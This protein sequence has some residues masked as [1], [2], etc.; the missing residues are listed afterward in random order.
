[1][2][3]GGKK[4][5]LKAAGTDATKQFD[6]FHNASVLQ[7]VAAPFLI[8]EVGLKEEQEE[9]ERPPLTVGYT[10]GDMIPFG[11]PMWQVISAA[12]T[13]LRLPYAL[14]RRNFLGTKTGTAHTI[15]TRIGRCARQS[16]SLLRNTSCHSATSGTKQGDFLVKCL[17][18][19]PRLVSWVLWCIMFPRTCIH[20]RCREALSLKIL[21]LFT[22]WL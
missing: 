10:F 2:R 8:G 20:T 12:P 18:R 1:M 4:V 14:T 15:T 17:S 16:V 3:T 22:M 13:F 21:M 19:Q 5:L 6:S 11:D 7:K 9:V